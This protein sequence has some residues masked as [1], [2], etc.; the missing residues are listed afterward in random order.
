NL[1]EVDSRYLGRVSYEVGLAEQARAWTEVR[2]NPD[3]AIIIGL[4]HETVITV[5]RREKHQALRL[6]NHLKQAPVCYVDRGGRLTLHSPG[7]LLIYPVVHLRMHHVS[8]RDFICLLL[9]VTKHVLQDYLIES[10]CYPDLSGLYTKQG[11]IVFLGLRILQG[12]SQH[13]LAVNIQND[14][15]LFRGFTACGVP[16]LA[17][18][19]VGTKC[20]LP[21]FF[22]QWAHTYKARKDDSIGCAESF[23]TN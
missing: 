7:Q 4:E 23:L 20:Q 3:R 2:N 12:I 19:K 15:S 21:E 1:I 13:G 9:N 11:K 18:D 8:V 10:F 5:G 22:L 14:L 17:L 16:D 6:P